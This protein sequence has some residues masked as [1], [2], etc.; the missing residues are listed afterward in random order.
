M[1]KT[2]SLIVCLSLLLSA[3]CVLS[4][5]G[6]PEDDGPEI[7]VYLGERIYDFDPTDYYVDSNAESVMSLLFEPLFSLDEN[8]KLQNAACEKYEIKEN[9]RKIVITL[10]ESYWSDGVAVKAEDFVNAWSNILLDPNDANPAA[11]LLFDIKNAAEI[12]NGTAASVFDFGA[13][14]TAP[15]ELTITYRKGANVDMLLKNLASVA[16][17]PIRQDI[18]TSYTSGYWSKL[19]NSAITNGPFMLGTMDE[20][21][22]EFTLV[23]NVGYHQSLDVKNHTKEVRPAQ[24]VSFL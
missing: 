23:R 16:T 5:C 22:N 14:A 8:G 15:N 19:L 24:L 12:K 3:L 2:V 13:V 20:D 4:S 10:R 9:E 6:A 17:A 7:S 21:E 18:V 1:K 11:V